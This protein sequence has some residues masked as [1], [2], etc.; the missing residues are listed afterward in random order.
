MNEALKQISL[1]RMFLIS[2]FSIFFLMLIGIGLE[3]V[4]GIDNGMIAKAL[5][6]LGLYFAPLTMIYRT[7]HKNNQS[8]KMWLKPVRIRILETLAG[9]I[10]PEMLGVGILLLAS[11]IFISFGS[12]PAEETLKSTTMGTDYWVQYFVLSCLLAPFCEEIIFRGFLFEKL[13]G[14]NSMKKSILITSLVFGIMHGLSGVSPAIVSIV[15]CV[16]YKKYNSL[17]PCMAVHFLHN[18]M[19]F[20]VR[21]S[22]LNTSSM[23]ST[24]STTT[25]FSPTELLPVVILVSMGLI[26]LVRFIKTNW[27]YTY[28]K[29]EIEA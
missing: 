28:P 18:L 4:F 19:V 5:G 17:I 26:W 8:I 3:K 15:L 7:L 11:T 20:L 9:V 25:S 10:F 22:V 2:L 27:K 24:S 21:Y 6:I 16:L 23:E 1:L 29:T 13:L 14:T 12:L